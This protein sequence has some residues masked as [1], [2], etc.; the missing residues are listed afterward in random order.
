[1]QSS[2]MAL[3]AAHGQ[4]TPMPEAAIFADTQWEPPEVYRWL[5]WLEKQLPFPVYRVTVGNLRQDTLA[6]MNSTLQRFS[7][8]PWFMKYDNGDQ[9]MGRRQCTKEYKLVPFKRKVVELT[10]GR[11]K[12]SAIAWIGI[13][14]DEASRMKPSRVQYIENR[15]P[16][17]DLRMNRQDCKDWMAKK[18]YPEPP[19]SACIGCPFHNNA[20]WRK[21]KEDPVLWADALEIDEAIRHQP[22][23]RAQQFAHRDLVPLSE[24]DL[25]TAED[26]GQLNLF[27]NECEGMC[28]V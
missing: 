6:G 7:A 21:V 1:M 19:R 4:I 17:I 3:M 25:S 12:K 23:I 15:W 10:R 5:D 26:R 22:K 27:I 11:L 13:T 16:L 9:G 18:G 14:T 8:I 20:E 28:G 24:V 2:T